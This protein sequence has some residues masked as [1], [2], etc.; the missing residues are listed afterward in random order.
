MK[1]HQ[2]IL[3]SVAFFVVLFYGENPG[4]NV[5]LFGFFLAGFALSRTIPKNRTPVLYILF[6]T[7]LLSASAFAWFGDF[8]SFLSL[9][10]SL[11]L[12]NLKSRSRNLASLFIIP[13]TAANLVTFVCRVANT[14]RWLPKTKS[15]GWF[16]KMLFVL[17]VP[18][19]LVVVFFAV[20]TYGSDHFAGFLGNFQW[21][22]D[23]FPLLGTAILG[24]FIAFN[25][26]DFVVDRIFY[27]NNTILSDDFGQ[28]QIQRMEQDRL[29]NPNILR[30]GGLVTF[31]ALNILLVFFIATYNYEQFFEFTNENTLSAETHE[32]VNAVIF[33]IALVIVVILIYFRG[34]LNFDGN[35]SSVKFFAKLWLVL[36]GVL[37]LSAFL[38]NAEYVQNFG[39]TY[40]RLGV[41]LFLILC[42]IGLTVTFLKVHRRKTNA[43]IFSRGA[44]C[45]YAAVLVGSFFNWG[46]IITAYNLNRKDFDLSYHLREIN[47]NEKI[48]LNS[49]KTRNSPEV[50]KTV[51]Q[52]IQAG[53]RERF[54]S[55]TLFY[56]QF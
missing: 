48:L 33:S 18:A 38:K 41:W 17:L 34:R 29:L 44:W 8:P 1:T 45:F 6:A 52:K 10:F 49:P 23:V 55:Q 3:L 4:V 37:V 35:A 43:Y 5:A 46:G 26:W 31:I 30:A 13:V 28:K 21:N 36:N 16:Q 2:L 11:L 47:F 56:E 24:F 7:S 19:V 39:L 42:F 51:K 15:K 9:F 12:L 40:K 14:N 50:R 27:K 32:R 25:Y 53:K 54:L 22:V 20:Y